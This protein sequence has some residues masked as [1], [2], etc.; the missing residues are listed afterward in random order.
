MEGD[1]QGQF[2]V[3]GDIASIKIVSAQQIAFVEF[4]THE[5]AKSA[6]SKSIASPPVLG[7][8]IAKVDWAKP[9]KAGFASPALPNALPPPV[10]VNPL[11]WG[12][13]YPSMNPNQ[14]GTLSASSTA[15]A[16]LQET[17][18]RPAPSTPGDAP[19]SAESKAKRPKT[20]ETAL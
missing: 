14:M 11:G 10:G 2:Y 6:I 8:Q 1:I 13:Y 12:V 16:P 5:A 19:T 15:G 7:G 17:K 18:K 9:P 20:A 3:F 4:A